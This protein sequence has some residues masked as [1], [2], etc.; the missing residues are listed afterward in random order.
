MRAL[1]RESVLAELLSKILIDNSIYEVVQR[2]DL[3]VSALRVEAAL[4]ESP[5]L[6]LPVAE[7]YIEG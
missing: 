3:Y 4:V 2:V 1:L 7:P 5:S 6:R